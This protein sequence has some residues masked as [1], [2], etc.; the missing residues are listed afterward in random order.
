MGVYNPH[1]PQILGEEW[2]PIRNENVSFS[3]SAD[4]VELGH[5]FTLTSPRR[6][7]DARF[8]TNDWPLVGAGQLI[9]A[10]IYPR[11][12]EDRTGPVQR[13]VIPVNAG[14]ITGATYSVDTSVAFAGYG[15]DLFSIRGDNAGTGQM[16]ASFATNQ[17]TELGGKRILG[18]N[19]LYTGFTYNSLT[20]GPIIDEDPSTA[21]TNVYIQDA[22]PTPN[23]QS[24]FGG[25]NDLGRGD[26][27]RSDYGRVRFGELTSLW[28]PGIT[29]STEYL[30][31]TYTDLLRFE[32]T[33]AQR[34]Q[35]FFIFQLP[36]PSD[37]LRI[38][39]L[40]LEVL[41]CEETR[42]A[43]GGGR[44]TYQL[45]TNV[46]QLRSMGGRAVDPIIP[47]GDYTVTIAGADPGDFGD[48]DALNSAVPP[49]NAL[50]ELYQVPSHPGVRVNTTLTVGETFTQE[51]TPILPQISLHTSGGVIPEV[52]VYGRQ[53]AA[54]VYGSLTPLQ[55]IDDDVV[56]AGSYPQVR[57]Y[58]RRFG[59]TAVPLILDSTTITG[60]GLSVSISPAQ[61]DALDELVDGWK[62]VTLR[63]PIAPTMGGL[64][65]NP[66]WRWSSPNELAGNRWEVLIAS[67]TAIS[68]IRGMSSNYTPSPQPLSA[69]T[70]NAPNAGATV[71][72]NW[73]SPPVSGTADDATSDIVL[74]FSQETALT[75]IAVSLQSQ[76]LT[77]FAECGSGPCC[78]PTAL[79]YNRVTWPYRPA[80]VLYDLF[81]RTL[82]ATWGT[83]DSGQAWGVTTGF[84][85]SGGQ[86]KHTPPATNTYY[87]SD[88]GL[89]LL[90]VT[91]SYKVSS[92]V[93]A[94]GSDHWTAVTLRGATSANQVYVR[95]GF[96]TNGTVSFYLT[97][98]VASVHTTLATMTLLTSYT[99]GTM[100]NVKFSLQ[101]T[102]FDAKAWVDGTP[103]PPDWL[104]FAVITNATNLVAGTIGTRQI[105][106]TGG[107]I[108]TFS[109]ENIVVTDNTL[110]YVELQRSDPI[111]DWQT[112]MKATNPALVQFND[113][114]M[115]VGVTSSYRARIVNV[116]N[117]AG[118]WSTTV[119]GAIAEP[120]ATMPPC[121]TNK[122]GILLFTSNEVQ[123]GTRNLAYAMT[124]PGTPS[125]DFQFPEAD[126]VS[127]SQQY[128]RDF[129][130]AFHGSERG[131]EVFQRTLLLA[132]AAIALPRLANVQSLR[133]LAWADL[134]YVCVRDGIG[135]RWL[136]AIIVPGDQVKR[137]RRLY[138]AQITVIEVTD[139]PSPVNP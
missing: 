5:G 33:S 45:G 41:Y 3:P 113:Y 42:V 40:A 94:S 51:Y 101:D 111:N 114:E 79:S 46:I 85:V 36:N 93:A 68:G 117:F 70:Y 98:V 55:H 58:A 73:I 104:L 130:V 128:D 106:G 125:E 6:P 26:A 77:G 139:T 116:L 20:G 44:F 74:M 84:S 16:S 56:A 63:F 31:W 23:Q 27:R 81:N 50:R 38:D 21:L 87:I 112:I 65:P 22:V 90:N 24:W 8:Y 30:P 95:V 108:P 37:T 92:S 48:G 138:N 126:N 102:S 1:I 53:N 137:N 99:P 13:A 10:N 122:R 89:S 34:L 83:A 124:W 35:V 12:L 28:N 135:D 76:A 9:E 119:T 61:W 133:D 43:Y 60:A 115:L 121:G 64:T 19:L 134:S 57:F 96:E 59:D 49:M 123:D 66:R 2:V 67:A 136:S 132:N 32:A 105:V 97:S 78:I 110:G 17:Y 7:R 47:A 82:P 25:M 75:G 120:G 62:E 86:G 15:V 109:Y 29:Q 100:I 52:H 127:I 80:N 54:Q 118:P 11:G 39:Y 129:Q 107:T 131:G 71:L 18:L 91:G 4:V 103:E 14:A 72:A 88:V 69:G